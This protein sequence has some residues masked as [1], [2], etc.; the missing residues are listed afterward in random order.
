MTEAD[1]EAGSAAGQ[2]GDFDPEQKRYL[3]GLGESVQIAKTARSVAGAV[4][5]RSPAAATT[6]GGPDA[7]ALE[8]ENR[9]LPPAASQTIRKSLS[10]RNI[11][12]TLTST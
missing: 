9:T 8:A 5:A 12:S 1:L 7:A 3:E 2:A 11:P 6:F 4:S 10:A